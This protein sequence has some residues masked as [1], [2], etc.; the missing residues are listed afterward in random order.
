[1]PQ[2]WIDGCS[3]QGALAH[4]KNGDKV[5]GKRHFMQ[6][7]GRPKHA[8]KVPSFFSFYVLGWKGGRGG[9]DFFSFFP[10]SQC[11]RTIF[12]SSFQWVPNIFPNIFSISPHF[13]PICLGK[14]CPPFTYI[15]GPKGRNCTVQNR[16]F[17]FG[18]SPLFCFFGVM[19]LSIGTLPEKKKKWRTWEAPHLINRR[20]DYF[21]KFIS[22][23]LA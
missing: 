1:V 2:H 17:C 19:G 8:L 22:L 12:L 21:P 23:P 4:A 11:V 9:W 14:W 3:L 16:A 5:F 20:G 7:M 10:A 18:E 6:P 15:G 13:Y